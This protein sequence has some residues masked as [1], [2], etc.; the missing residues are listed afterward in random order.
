M[1][2]PWAIP[3]ETVESLQL[4]RDYNSTTC[5][6]VQRTQVISHHVNLGF[7]RWSNF[8]QVKVRLLGEN[9]ICQSNDVTDPYKEILVAVQETCGQH[10]PCVMTSH[11]T[12]GQYNKC[13]YMCMCPD[14]QCERVTITVKEQAFPASYDQISICEVEFK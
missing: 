6:H 5:M 2:Q 14:N 4:L 3:E 9:V 7:Q 12:N 11:G 10:R 13:I 8:S 1:V